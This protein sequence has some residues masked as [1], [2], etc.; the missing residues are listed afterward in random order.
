MKIACPL[1]LAKE[2]GKVATR[3]SRE[4]QMPTG[5]AHDERFG[6]VRTYHEDVLKLTVK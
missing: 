4:M 1:H 5:V 2:W 3:L 6:R